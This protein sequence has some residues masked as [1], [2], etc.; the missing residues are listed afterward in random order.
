MI[1]STALGIDGIGIEDNFF[2]LGG[3]SILALRLTTGIGE[4]LGE[5]VYISALLDAPTISALA[6]RLEKDYR[7]AVAALNSNAPRK[8]AD[9]QLPVVTPTH[10][11]R[12]NRSRSQT[13]SRPTSWAAAATLPWVTYPHISI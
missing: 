7:D 10:D 5:Y 11:A 3:D 2:E 9:D 8:A 4:L 1:W 13:Y 6:T 12:L